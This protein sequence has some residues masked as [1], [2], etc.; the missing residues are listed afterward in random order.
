MKFYVIAI[1]IF[2]L[3][4][5]S[6][7]S[8]SSSL[9]NECTDLCFETGGVN[10]QAAKDA[11]E[12]ACSQYLYYGGEDKINELI[13]AYRTESEANEVIYGTSNELDGVDI[14]AVENIEECQDLE[15]DS[16]NVCVMKFIEADED[17]DDALVCSWITTE[18]SE[19]LF[20]LN[21]RKATKNKDPTFCLPTD[22]FEGCYIDYLIDENLC[23]APKVDQMEQDLCILG[24]IEELGGDL[25]IDL[26]R[27]GFSSH[28]R[29]VLSDLSMIEAVYSSDYNSCDSLC[30]NDPE[31]WSR[32]SEDCDRAQCLSIVTI[33]DPSKT[34]RE[35]NEHYLEDPFWGENE[36]IV[37]CLMA[38]AKR[39]NDLLLCEDLEQTSPPFVDI[40]KSNVETWNQ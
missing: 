7:T 27:S 30:E 9:V 13:D 17:F 36:G 10:S 26:I 15:Q 31:G 34:Y 6:C 20:T 29:T 23:P 35:C 33:Y 11:C 25:D 18:K 1:L 24:F 3:F 22:D 39:D 21:F 38:Q 19:C 32:N 14:N 8:S 5:F 16:K 12:S 4:L 40:C 37:S 28:G 2:S